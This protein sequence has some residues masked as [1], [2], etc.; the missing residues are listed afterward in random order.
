MPLFGR[1]VI[2]LRIQF[3]VPGC[4]MIARGIGRVRTMRF[5]LCN[6]WVLCSIVM[7]GRGIVSPG[8]RFC[9]R[10]RALRCCFPFEEFAALSWAVRLWFLRRFRRRI[11]L[12]P[13]LVCLLVPSC[14]VPYEDAVPELRIFYESRREI[15]FLDGK[16]LSLFIL[17]MKKGVVLCLNKRQTTS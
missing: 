3:W 8:C 2:S 13:A 11:C 15:L 1:R 10:G 7:L 12:G 5:G 16:Y 14:A 9:A 17:C 4:S 6:G